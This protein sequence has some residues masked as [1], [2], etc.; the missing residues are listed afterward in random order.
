LRWLSKG[1]ALVNVENQEQRV[2][3]FLAPLAMFN[4]L[5]AQFNVMVLR[6][7]NKLDR[8]EEQLSINSANPVTTTATATLRKPA[9]F[10]CT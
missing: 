8:L 7:L 9:W 1:L 10:S 3:L 4:K 2:L 5:I 6:L